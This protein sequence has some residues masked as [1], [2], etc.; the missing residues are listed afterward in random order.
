MHASSIIRESS[1]PYARGA[2]ALLP[3]DLV[4]DTLRVRVTLLQS[5]L[6]VHVSLASRSPTCYRI[7][8]TRQMLTI[9]PCILFRERLRSCQSAISDQTNR[10]YRIVWR[11]RDCS[12]LPDLHQRRCPV[13]HIAAAANIINS[14]F[15]PDGISRGCAAPL[16]GSESPPTTPMGTPPVGVV[17]SVYRCAPPTH[18][19]RT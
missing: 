13:A 7:K 1:M 11:R 17:V 8:P 6:D 16:P 18:P 15:C 19:V 5:T 9:S 2:R 14:L 12:L 3:L 4:L 10:I